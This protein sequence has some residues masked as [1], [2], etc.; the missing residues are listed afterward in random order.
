MLKKLLK[1]EFKY[2]ARIMIP[3]LI[4]MLGLTI[5]ASGLF[6]VNLR[7]S[8]NYQ[9]S[10][11]ETLIA[12]I[13][14]LVTGLFSVLALLLLC[15]AVIA[16][17]ILLAYRYYKNLFD[18][19]GYLSFTLPVSANAQLMTKLISA[20]VWI[21]ITGIVAFISCCVFAIFGTASSGIVNMT[22]LQEAEEVIRYLLNHIGVNEVLFIIEGIFFILF[23]LIFNILLIY[24]AIT[25]GSIISKRH[26]IVTAVGLYIAINTVVG[27]VQSVVLMFSSYILLGNASME[28]TSYNVTEYLHFTL[29]SQSVLMVIM[30]VISYLLIKN[31]MEKKLNLP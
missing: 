13:I 29:I 1:Y 21:C 30:G 27:I 7:Y 22:L 19:E 16:I 11:G 3:I 9:W 18:S 31:N 24:L 10:S 23:S 26:K 20:F 4:A 15:A 12:N 17:T 5:I 2:V 8:Q 6:T 28:P 14:S 25:I